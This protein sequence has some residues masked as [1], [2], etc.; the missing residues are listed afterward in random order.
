MIERKFVAQRI[1][2]FEI[3]EYIAENLKKVG[4]S[5][6]KMQKTPLGE[7]IV[8]Y[9]SRPGLIVGRKGQNIKQLTKTLGLTP[10]G[11]IE[12]PQAL[13]SFLRKKED[14][15]ASALL[16]GV[17]KKT[18]S[19]SFLRVGKIYENNGTEIYKVIK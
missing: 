1:K 10:L 6:T 4:H 19:V 16:V 2:E 12:I 13:T 5:H 14:T 11:F 9:A 3:Q 15:P 18:V 7:K 17:N 8:I